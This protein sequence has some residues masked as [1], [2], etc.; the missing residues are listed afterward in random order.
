MKL[1]HLSA[2]APV[3]IASLCAFAAGERAARAEPALVV[4]ELFTS[5]GC[6]SC[7]PADA[8]IGELAAN[9]AVLPLSEHVD[10]WDHLGWKDPF[11]SPANTRRQRDYARAFG[12]KYVYTPQV[13]V[14]G[15]AQVAGGDRAAVLRAIEAAPAPAV[16]LA[17]RWI[18][19]DRLVVTLGAASGTPA[20]DLWLVGYEPQ[21]TTVVG[22]GENSG[23]QLTNYH[24]ARSFRK[25]GSWRGAPDSF[26]V[27]APIP[28]NGGS[29]CAILLQ[30]D[31]GGAIL[32]AAKC[33]ER[34]RTL[35]IP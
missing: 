3:V 16:S 12:L 24:V 19:A 8:L 21:R 32:S 10:Y 34:P 22:T 7:P 18:S 25:I 33:G 20:A 26:V 30:A 2:G 4:V 27:E 15:Q 6:S 35:A 31:A 11:A 17:L 23:R 9:T 5:Q 14:Q 13:V 1:P 29:G 28:E